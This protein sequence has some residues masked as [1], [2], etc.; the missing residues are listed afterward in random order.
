MDAEPAV[1]GLEFE[2]YT[3]NEE[4]AT[5]EEN[6]VSVCARVMNGTLN[7][8]ITLRLTTSSP[9]LDSETPG[10][11]ASAMLSCKYYNLLF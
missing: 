8:I 10:I 4:N 9:G 3:V 1:I 5:N 6:A 7:R 2:N 11:I